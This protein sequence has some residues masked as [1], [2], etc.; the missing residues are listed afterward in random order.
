LD[1]AG[2]RKLKKKGERGPDLQ[3]GGGKKS[4]LSTGRHLDKVCRKK[5]AASQKKKNPK[6]GGRVKER[7]S[8]NPASALNDGGSGCIRER[9]RP[10]AGPKKKRKVKKKN[11]WEGKPAHGLREK[12]KD[13][14]NGVGV[15]KRGRVPEVS[16]CPKKNPNLRSYILKPRGKPALE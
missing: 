2:R 16:S 4:T 10:R 15:R 8:E 7:A 6:G 13:L 9:T 1:N 5:R 3:P 14:G 12:A 11:R